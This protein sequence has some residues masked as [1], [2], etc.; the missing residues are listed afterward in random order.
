MAL[1]TLGVRKG[2]L[3]ENQFVAALSTHQA[4]IYGAYPR[5]GALVPVR[6]RTSCC[7]TQSSRS[8]RR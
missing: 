3:S 6:M 2:R 5:K 7:G 4:R 1:W 8:R